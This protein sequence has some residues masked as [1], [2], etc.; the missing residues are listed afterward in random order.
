MQIFHHHIYEFQKGLR[1]LV[2]CTEKSQDREKIEKRLKKESIPYFIH[3]VANDK[4]NV[5]FGHQACI[6]VVKTFETDKLNELSTQED[7]ILGIMLGYDRLQQC[8]RY[9]ERKAKHQIAI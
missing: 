3:E 8:V 1:N 2:L 5:Y 4:I 7:F 6:N 9:L